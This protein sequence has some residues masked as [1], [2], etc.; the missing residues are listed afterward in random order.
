VVTAGKNAFASRFGPAKEK[1]LPNFH[2]RPTKRSDSPRRQR[3]ESLVSTQYPIMST[4]TISII[5]IKTSLAEE[6]PCR[7]ALIAEP[8]RA[9]APVVVSPF[10]VVDPFAF[11]MR[12]NAS[13]FRYTLQ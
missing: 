3:A 12:R 2:G 7:D 1:S 13:F 9:L 8:I 6:R 11:R 5:V 4:N 10:A